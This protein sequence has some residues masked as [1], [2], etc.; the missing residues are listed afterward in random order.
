[1]GTNLSPATAT[2]QSY[3]SVDNNTTAAKY[4]LNFW[5]YT[6]LSVPIY[7]NTHQEGDL[8]VTKRWVYKKGKD[9]TPF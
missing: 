4:L 2:T 5:C 7:I 1:M 8:A 6:K 3:A 9:L